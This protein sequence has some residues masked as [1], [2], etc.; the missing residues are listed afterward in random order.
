M[1][2][3]GKIGSFVLGIL[4]RREEFKFITQALLKRVRFK[5]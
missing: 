5:T 4:A 3:G 1:Y 2:H